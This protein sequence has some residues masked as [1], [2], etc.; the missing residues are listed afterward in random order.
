MSTDDH[1]RIGVEKRQTSRFADRYY[2]RILAGPLSGTPSGQSG[3][4]MFTQVNIVAT[5]LLC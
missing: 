4:D 3:V 1:R 2:P 5:P